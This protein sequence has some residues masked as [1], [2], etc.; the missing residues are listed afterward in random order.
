M[1]DVSEGFGDC[2]KYFEGCLLNTKEILVKDIEKRSGEKLKEPYIVYLIETRCF[3]SQND[4]AQQSSCLWRRYSEFD[5]LRNYLQTTYPSVIIPPLPEKKTNL[6]AFRL[7]AENYN[8]E[9]IERRRHGLEVSFFL[10]RIAKHSQLGLDEYFKS[11]LAQEEGWKESVVESGFQSKAESKFKSI[12]AS[13]SVKKPD[14]K[15][16][17]MK[18]YSQTL[19]FN[20]K[21]PR[22]S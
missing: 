22:S 11:F 10:H 20:R 18:N 15:Y 8:M 9:F 1:A 19:K 21:F 17:D 6:A 3:N 16:E 13:Y 7:N 12:S 5:L 14:K 4:D 2:D